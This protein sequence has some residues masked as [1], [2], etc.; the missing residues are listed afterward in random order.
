MGLWVAEDDEW[1][2]L[3]YIPCDYAVDGYVLLAKSHIV[4]RQPG[5]GK[6]KL[7]L[8]LKLKDIKATAPSSFSFSDAIEMLRWVEREYGV[9]QFMT[10]E[11]AAYLGWVNEADAVHF[12]LDSL[13]PNGK[14]AVREDDEKPFLVSEIQLIMFGD[15]Y[16]QSL[17]LL[18]QH[19][20]RRNL[21][22]P[23]DN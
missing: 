15:D 2:L 23:S 14:V 13:D 20:Q 22:K 3:R 8:I 6:K 7:E 18:W 1:V 19:K 12:W 11:T 4:S 10:E 16:A 5:R 21:P 9:M 17:K